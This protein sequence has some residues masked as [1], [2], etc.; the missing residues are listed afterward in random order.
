MLKEKQSGQ[1]ETTP[2]G[3]EVN[4][5]QLCSVTRFLQIASAQSSRETVDNF[6]VI[7]GLYLS[8]SELHLHYELCFS[9]VAINLFSGREPRSSSPV[10]WILAPYQS[11][12]GQCSVSVRSEQGHRQ[13]LAWPQGP[14]DIHPSCYRDG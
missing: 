8:N 10:Q 14:G 11:I 6:H 7:R 1:K 4:S 3:T 2:T 12:G 13:R 5:W 9:T